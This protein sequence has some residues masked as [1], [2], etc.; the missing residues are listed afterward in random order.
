MVRTWAGLVTAATLAVVLIACSST[1]DRTPPAV[2]PDVRYVQVIAHPDDDIIFMNP[3][4]VAGIR[5]GRPTTGIY[6]TAGETDKADANGY[7]A[8]RQAGTRAAYARM[9]GAADDWQA[10]RL[11]VD[12]HHAVE[13]YVLKQRPQVQ[14]MFVNLPE[15]NDPHAVGG[16]EAFVR[17]WNDDRDQL[18]LPTLTPTDGVL[19]QPY[20]YTHS[21]VVQL[22]VKLFTRLQPTVVRAQDP[23]PDSR[24]L[25]DNIKFHDHPDHVV[26]ARFT[27]AATRLYQGPRFVSENYRDYNVAEVPP[28][29]SAA[30]R[31][32]KVNI[33]SAY[34][35][36]DS[37]VS[38]G[39]PYD[40]WLQ[41]EYQR[42]PRGSSWAA[43]GR[44]YVVLNGQLY[45]CSPGGEWA[46]LPWADGPLNQ[47]VSAAGGWV[48]GKRATDNK[49]LALINGS[50]Q[51]LGNPDDHAPGD[52]AQV[53]SPVTDGK[54]VYVKNGRG[55]LSV[56]RPGREWTDIG[57]T[58]IQDGIAISGPDVYASTRDKVL[59]W[60][61]DKLDPGFTSL[62]PAGPPSAAGSAVVYRTDAGEVALGTRVLGGFSGPG[63]PTVTSNGHVFAR[64]SAGG[65]AVWAG[66]GWRDL[67]GQVLD[68]PAPFGAGVVALGPDGQVHGFSDS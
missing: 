45:G 32:D 2:Q 64:T 56:W 16:K 5:A 17:L 8:R 7:A 43:D 48:V 13:L 57:G 9:A 53:G 10:S 3:D 23:N 25:K 40:G 65:V 54:A 6:L 60:H 49:V 31:A 41:R 52:P 38:L 62:K 22:L 34:V 30:D 18:R 15:N 37:D 50:W 1:P 42:Y 55:R 4:L 51:S 59:H 28:N 12:E 47:A 58:D 36:H 14:V 33:F 63:N 39:Y 19:T 61:L 66:A 21:D 11:D 46:T 27:D 20:L 67:G 68:Q 35:P 44:A 24:F 29:L 26:A